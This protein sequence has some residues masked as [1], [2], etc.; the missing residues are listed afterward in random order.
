MT[1]HHIVDVGPHPWIVMELLPGDT[2]QDRLGRGVLTPL[3]A[4]ATTF[5]RT[6]LG[7]AWHDYAS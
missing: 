1:I 3:E 5:R 4:A 6:A 7:P 2:L